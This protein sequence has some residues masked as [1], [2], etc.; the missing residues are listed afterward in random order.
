VNS[1]INNG[2][3][4]QNL[5]NPDGCGSSATPNLMPSSESSFNGI[6]T[7]IKDAYSQ[8]EEVPLFNHGHM[9]SYFVSQ[10]AVDGLASGD[11]KAINKSAKYL[12]DCG[13]VQGMEVGYTS[14]SLHLR[15]TCIPEMRKDRVYKVLMTLDCKTYDINTATKHYRVRSTTTFY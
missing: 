12:Y 2:W 15:A 4:T 3:A 5:V 6:W 13:H 14:A 8:P 7:N 9:I 11:V 1:Y 10:T